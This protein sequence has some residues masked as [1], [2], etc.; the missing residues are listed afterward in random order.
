V[1][2]PGWTIRAAWFPDLY[3]DGDTIDV[4]ATWVVKVEEPFGQQPSSYGRSLAFRVRL[5]GINAAKLP[6]DAGRAAAAY[7]HDWCARA[8]FDVICADGE[9]YKYGGP[10]YT[11]YAQFM[12]DLTRGTHKLT[13]D[14]LEHLLAVYWDGTGPRP[15]DEGTTS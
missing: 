7:V 14:L 6:T 11:P 10:R 1:T 3:A 12:A 5:P 2:G 13:D 9:H 4:A 8:R 15:A